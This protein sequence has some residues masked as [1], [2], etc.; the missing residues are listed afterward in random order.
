[1]KEVDGFLNTYTVSCKA[2]CYSVLKKLARLQ[3][4]TAELMADIE[5]RIGSFFESQQ[6]GH[7]CLP[8]A[9]EVSPNHTPRHHSRG[10]R[11]RRLLLDTPTQRALSQPVASSTGSPV[12]YVSE[13]III[14][15]KS[16]LQIQFVNKKPGGPSR[17][18]AVT[19]SLRG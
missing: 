2:G 4:E 12:D 10:Y 11:Q 18:S 6:A 15:F 13:L 14:L 3:K 9:E 7:A 17:V 5:K 16:F 8:S 19:R 1:M